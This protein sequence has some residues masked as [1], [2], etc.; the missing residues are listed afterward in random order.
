MTEDATRQ[1]GRAEA[2]NGGEVPAPFAS[3]KPEDYHKLFE[4]ARYFERGRGE[5]IF[6]EG[7][8]AS[9]I[10]LICRGKVKLVQQ[11]PDRRKKQILKIL[12]TGDLLGEETFFAGGRH[13]TYARALEPTQLYFFSGE[14]FLDFLKRHPEMA[15]KL[16]ERLAQELKACQRMLVE[17]AYE[18]GEE[19]LARLLLELSRKFGVREG[20]ACLIDL[21]LSRT[22]LAELLG[23]RPETT[24]RILSR[25]RAK[26]IVALKRQRLVILNEHRLSALARLAPSRV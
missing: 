4:R 21:R 16:L 17:L 7:M 11:T 19:R 13:T 20:E 14:D 12:G 3:L 8:P 23:L 25:W 6:Q 1:R 15:L 2:H 5:L 26:G 24:I 22:E 10:Y 9:G 18:R